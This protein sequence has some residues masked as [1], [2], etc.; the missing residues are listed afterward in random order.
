MS[1]RPPSNILIK[2]LVRGVYGASSAKGRADGGRRD[3]KK[4]HEALDERLILR[5]APQAELGRVTEH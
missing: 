5:V 4:L 3:G 1:P 2:K